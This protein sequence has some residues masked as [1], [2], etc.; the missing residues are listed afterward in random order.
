MRP[1]E[2]INITR[3][4]KNILTTK[5]DVEEAVSILKHFGVDADTGSYNYEEYINKRFKNNTHTQTN[6]INSMG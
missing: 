3:E 2:R 1:T 6:N 4:I 5:Y